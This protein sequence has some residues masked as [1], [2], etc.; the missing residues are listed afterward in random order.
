MAL[1]WM[2]EKHSQKELSPEIQ[3]V[4]LT[5]TVL[6][7][8]FSKYALV[9]TAPSLSNKEVFFAYNAQLNKCTFR[10]K[11]LFTVPFFFFFRKTTVL[12]LLL[13]YFLLWWVF[14]ARHGL[15]LVAAS[16]GYFLLWCMGFSLQ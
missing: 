3:T 13:L 11:S 8:L 9:A 7:L 14:L 16:G 2:A 6:T 1:P 10:C 4:S 5:E 15:S 12:V